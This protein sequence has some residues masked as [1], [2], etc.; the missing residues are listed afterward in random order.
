MAN[1]NQRIYID[2]CDYVL[3]HTEGMTCPYEHENCLVLMFEQFIT[4]HQTIDTPFGQMSQFVNTEQYM[5]TFISLS[6]YYHNVFRHSK[7]PFP[8]IR[9]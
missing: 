4:R 6:Y 9:K 1:S 8:F 5:L 7:W 2:I 3:P